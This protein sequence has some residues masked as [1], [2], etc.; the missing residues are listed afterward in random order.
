LFFVFG[1]TSQLVNQKKDHYNYRFR[2]LLG[3]SIFN[4]SLSL[5][6]Y[7][8]YFCPFGKALVSPSAKDNNYPFPLLLYL[9]LLGT[10]N[11]FCVVGTG[12]FV[13]SL[14]DRSM[15]MH[16]MRRNVLHIH[17]Q[18]TVTFFLTVVVVV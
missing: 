16:G 17:T 13:G 3:D 15:M 12:V 1:R 10:K 11:Y 9:K 6:L 18:S 5:S 2:R 14:D 8:C 4:L 7:Y